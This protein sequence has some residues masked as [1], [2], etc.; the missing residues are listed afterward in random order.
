LKSER[1]GLS[2]LQMRTIIAP[3]TWELV[4]L[5]YIAGEGSLRTLAR[6]HGLSRSSVEH[7]AGLERW[8]TLR[9]QRQDAELA[10][11]VPPLAIV[12][13]TPQLSVMPAP[14]SPEWIG[15]E[16]LD[17]FRE[18][19]ALVREGRKKISEYLASAPTLDAKA[20]SQVATAISTLAESSARLLGLNGKQAKVRERRANIVPLEPLD[21]T[22][23]NNPP[24][25]DAITSDA[26]AR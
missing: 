22:E 13:A 20:L 21:C 4:K 23:V 26:V 11:L 18:S 5:G 25:D 14:M 17:H 12:P 19:A 8:T 3:R 6:R 9:K 2:S 24:A 10:K 15:Q 16:Q 7:R 1:L